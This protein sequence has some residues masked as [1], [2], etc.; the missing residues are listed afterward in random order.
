MLSIGGFASAARLSL[1]ALRLYDQLG[2]LKPRDV[3]RDSGYRY[4]HLD[5]LGAARLIRMMRQMEMPLATI[6]LVLAAP[7]ADA[8]RLVEDYWQQR[9]RRM[10]EAR[11]VVHDL[12]A[13]LQKEA[14]TMALDVSVKTIAPQP[15]ISIIRRVT[16]EQ[17]DSHIRDSVQRLRALA[18]THS[19]SVTGDPFGIYHGG[20]NH[21]DDGPMEVCLPVQR[22]VEADGV[23]ARELAGGTAAYVLLHGEYCEF[24]RVL[25]GYDAVYDWIRQNGYETVEPPREVW[26]SQYQ[27]DEQLEV[28]WMFRAATRDDAQQQTA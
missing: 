15:I 27:T 6:R 22:G 19:L 25:E 9:E 1:K 7:P 18:A 14:P 23:T 3:D 17:L 5:Q 2:I 8:A 26:H 21:D 28:L 12:L 10:V 16:I 24:P 4:Y 20:V 13:A 11:R